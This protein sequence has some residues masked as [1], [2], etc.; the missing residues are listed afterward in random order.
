VGLKLAVD[1]DGALGDTRPL[2]HDWLLQASGVLDVDPSGLPGDRATAAEELDRAGAGNWRT[3]L[4]RYAEDRAPVYLRR[5]ADVA[6]ALR[7]LHTAGAEV[8]VF[9]DAPEEL[10]TLALAHLGADR[11]VGSLHAGVDAE[12]RALGHLGDGATVVRTRSELTAAAR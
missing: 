3:L 6:G 4:A 1:L 5:S 9:T 10:A 8:A 12:Q 11:R 7:A 2:W